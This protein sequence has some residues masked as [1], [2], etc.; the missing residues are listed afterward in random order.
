MLKGSKIQL[1]N[2]PMDAHSECHFQYFNGFFMLPKP[3]LA[4]L[5]I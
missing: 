4:A 3:A 2:L 5:L 1:K